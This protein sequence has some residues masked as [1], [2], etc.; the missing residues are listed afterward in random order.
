MGGGW[1]KRGVSCRSGHRPPPRAVA[2]RLGNRLALAAQ[3]PRPKLRSSVRSK[4]VLSGGASVAAK[5]RAQLPS[6]PVGRRRARARAREPRGA[7]RAEWT[8]GWPSSPVEEWSAQIPAREVATPLLC[9]FASFCSAAPSAAATRAPARVGAQRGADVGPTRDRDRA[10]FSLRCREGGSDTSRLSPGAP[11]RRWCGGR[12]LS[13]PPPRLT[14]AAAH[15]VPALGPASAPP[16]PGPRA[17]PP[18]RVPPPCPRSLP[19]LQV[20]FA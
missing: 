12:A 16:P 18:L 3:T 9:R 1:R 6:A 10:R 13:P 7:R 20:S 5:E 11:R 4:R 19:F 17:H 8:S 2:P 14:Q 15:P